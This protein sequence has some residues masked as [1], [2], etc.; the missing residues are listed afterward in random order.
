MHFL[1]TLKGYINY[2]VAD[3]GM[4]SK[5]DVTNLNKDDISLHIV[6]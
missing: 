4:F 3:A 2:H 1:T 6:S 5:T